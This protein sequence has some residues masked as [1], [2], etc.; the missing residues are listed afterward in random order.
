[1][2]GAGAFRALMALARLILPALLILLAVALVLR[3]LRRGGA[4]PR[5]PGG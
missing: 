1:M 2:Y 4:P 5:R 3:A